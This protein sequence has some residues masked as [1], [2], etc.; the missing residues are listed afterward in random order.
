MNIDQYAMYDILSYVDNDTLFVLNVVNKQYRTYLSKRIFGSDE[1]FSYSKYLREK[2]MKHICQANSVKLLEYVRPRFHFRVFFNVC[3]Y[4]DTDIVKAIIKKKRFRNW[5]PGLYGACRR[6]DMETVQLM[7]SKG[8]NGWEDAFIRACIGGNL[9]IV[10]LMMSK[11]VS[12]FAEKWLFGFEKA[13]KKGHFE[14]V[15][16]LIEKGFNDLYMGL[17]MACE[18]GHIKIVQLLL[19][20]T[21]KDITFGNGL[22]DSCKNGHLEITRLL[23]NNGANKCYYCG[24]SMEEHLK[25]K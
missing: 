7:I 15:Q 13:C 12:E 4:C 2:D 20:I 8:A 22:F 6:G 9:E 16:L 3:R 5:N 14:I 1:I 10:K 21:K 25:R 11:D 18:K 19:S 23:I 24:K 17:R